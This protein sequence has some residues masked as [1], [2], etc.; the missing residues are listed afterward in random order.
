[1]RLIDL[2]PRWYALEEGGPRVGLS[3]LCPHCMSQRLCVSFHHKGRELMDDTYIHAHHGGDE[4]EHIWNL[5][6]AE[7]FNTLT[8]SP[9]IDASKSG[10]WHGFI[11]GGEIR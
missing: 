6:S 1:M 3:F 11:Q 4:R 2:K 7:D 9:S 8:L 5:D 10:H